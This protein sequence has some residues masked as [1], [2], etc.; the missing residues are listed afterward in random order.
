M[1]PPKRIV[2]LLPSSTEICFA[3]GLGDRVV[4]V[5]H[6][7]DFPLKVSGRPV[8]TRPKGRPACYL[9]RDRSAGARPARGRAQRLPHRRGAPARAP[10][11][12]HHHAGRLRGLRGLLRRSARGDGAAP[13]GREE[14]LI[15]LAAHT[16]RRAGRHR[17]GRACCRCRGRRPP[18]HRR[19]THE[20]RAP[21]GTDRPAPAPA[22]PRPGVARAADGRR[23]PD[24]SSSASRAARQSSGTMARLRS[25]STGRPSWRPRPR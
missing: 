11:G 25:L 1:F 5:S 13:G 8:L 6:E 12:P 3:V 19:P 14:H 9:G 15:A 2:S 16:R 10:T 7:C 22:R 17:A 23:P 24:P 21:P 20:A 18:T 4:G